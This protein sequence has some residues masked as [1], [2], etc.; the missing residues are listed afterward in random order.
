MTKVT[1]V[2]REPGRLKPDYF[3]EFELPEVPKSGAY[4]S[5]QRPD[6]PAPYGEDLIVEQVW[7][8]L[9]HPETGGS[10]SASKIGGVI[11]VF[12]ECSP[13][14]GPWSSD[15]WRDSLKVHLERGEVKEFDID[16]LSF[17]QDAL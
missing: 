5:I 11:E 2:V 6:E 7:W 13:A 17:R 4:I 12:V 8:R 14:I 1:I 15:A 3:L 9:R 10:S 16:R